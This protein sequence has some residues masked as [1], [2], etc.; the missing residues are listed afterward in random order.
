[1]EKDPPS[2]PYDSPIFNF[3]YFTKIYEIMKVGN[4]GIYLN[5]YLYPHRTNVM[6]F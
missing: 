1:M 6:N 5:I 3:L 2:I 4:H